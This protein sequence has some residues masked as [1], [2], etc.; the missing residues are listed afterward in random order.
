MEVRSPFDGEVLRW[1]EGRPW[2][3]TYF[4]S[5]SERVMKVSRQQAD[6]RAQ[7]MM[8]TRMP[9]MAAIIERDNVELLVIATKEWDIPLSDGTPAQNTPEEYRSAYNKYRWLFEQGNE[10][11]GARVNFSKALLKS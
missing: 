7:A 1:P 2:T 10:F 3:I 11:A 6:R 8:R 5:D 9:Q 4:G